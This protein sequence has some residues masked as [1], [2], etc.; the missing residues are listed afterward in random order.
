M[1]WTSVHDYLV[2]VVQ[3]PLMQVVELLPPLFV[4]LFEFLLLPLPVLLCVID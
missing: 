4:A 3:T 1:G 2:V